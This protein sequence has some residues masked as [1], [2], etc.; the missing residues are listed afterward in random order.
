[1]STPHSPSFDPP[2]QPSGTLPHPAWP[3][4]VLLTSLV[5]V[6]G[7]GGWSLARAADPAAADHATKPA[8]Q[9]AAPAKAEAAS[10]AAS[11][12]LAIDLKKALRDKLI[13]KKKLTLIV[14]D[15][16]ARPSGTSKTKA[17]EAAPAPTSKPK[18]DTHAAPA[19]AHPSAV[20][21]R[22]APAPARAVPPTAH[23]AAAT[24][25]APTVNT[26]ASRDEIKAKAAALA[27]HP[28]A[29]PAHG[30]TAHDEVHWS[31]S[32]ETGPQAWGQLKP[33]FNICAIGKRQSPIN[34]EESNTL[35]GPAE[36]LAFNYQSS[37]GLVVNNGHTIQVDLQGNNTLTV[38]GSTYSLV[39]FH[40]H[41]PSE[42]Q[43]NNRNFAMVAHLV[44]KNPEGQLAVVAVLLEP[45]TANPL[46]EKVW[47]YM[48]LDVNDQVRMPGGLLDMNEL[49]PKDQRYY[50]FIGSLTT[51]PC[52]EGVLWM[53]LKQP[54]QISK[55]QLKLFQQLYPNNARPVQPAN[56]R[57]VRN[58]Q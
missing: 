1:M 10:A 38:R 12:E 17:A 13:D 6:L 36:P 44:H 30:A 26:H 8:T 33:E 43:V 37:A 24:P 53:V 11:S 21:A 47:T 52:T 3:H 41:T 31:Y 50:Q 57:P 27:G 18:A 49:L 54:T 34:I 19:V 35:Q 40:F 23:P 15:L 5:L 28:T 14:T 39:Q 16:P 2:R 58:A 32:G 4:H 55:E 20:A 46:L 45:G 25:H 9:K 51:P 56:S 29:T 7:A 48:P 42:E 22:P